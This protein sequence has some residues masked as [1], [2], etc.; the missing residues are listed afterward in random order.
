MGSYRAAMI[1]EQRDGDCALRRDRNIAAALRL[2]T[3]WR[4]LAERQT[5]QPLL[6][7]ASLR[8]MLTALDWRS[9]TDDAAVGDLWLLKTP[10]ALESVA[11]YD[12]PP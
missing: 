6:N 8:D 12:G 2:S 1:G 3:C 10:K 7:P 5:W 4:R 9:V 11:I